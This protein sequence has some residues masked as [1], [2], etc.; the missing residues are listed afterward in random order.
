ML[1]SAPDHSKAPKSK[2]PNTIS[3][4]EVKAQFLF[5]MKHFSSLSEKYIPG[6]FF[7]SEEANSAQ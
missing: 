2:V 7:Y 6:D 3:T 5:V 4:E 1:F